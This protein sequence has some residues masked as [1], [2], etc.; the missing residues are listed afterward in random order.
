VIA[1]L[2]G[3]NLALS[4]LLE[5]VAV[6]AFAYWGFTIS[7]SGTL[8]V[9]LGIGLAVASIVLWGIYA[10]PK[11]ERR[12]RGGALIAFKLVFFALAVI[13]LISA[14]S[15][16]LGIILAA[17]VVVNLVLAYAWQQETL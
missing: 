5:L 11:S 17:T 16:T 13:A 14:G 6:A 8:N 3:I 1:L 9:V 15:T 4:F 2:K 7:D 10:A 12:L